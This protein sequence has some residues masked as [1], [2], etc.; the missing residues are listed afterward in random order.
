MGYLA[1]GMNVGE[2]VIMAVATLILFFPKL[3][4]WATP[5]IDLPSLAVDGVGI[6]LWAVVFLMQKARIRRN[7]DLTLPV[8]EQKKLRQARAGT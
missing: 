5:M 2:W 3:I 1:C 8:H 4:H 6:A 7:P